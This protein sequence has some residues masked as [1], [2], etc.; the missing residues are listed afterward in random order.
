M[1]R[2]TL[3]PKNLEEKIRGKNKDLEEKIEYYKKYMDLV[4]QISQGKYH[5]LENKRKTAKKKYNDGEITIY[6]QTENGWKEINTNNA[7]LG[8]I[9][10]DMTEKEITESKIYSR[11]AE[12]ALADK[13]IPT[14]SKNYKF[15]PSNLDEY[16][17]PT[18]TFYLDS[19]AVKAMRNTPPDN[20]KAMD[21]LVEKNELFKKTLIPITEKESEKFG[22]KDEKIGEG[23]LSLEE[24]LKK[25]SENYSEKTHRLAKTFIDI[26]SEYF[27]SLGN[28]MKEEVEN[29][30]EK[31]ESAL[32]EKGYNISTENKRFY[33]KLHSNIVK[34]KEKDESN[35]GIINM[36][37]DSILTTATMMHNAIDDENYNIIVSE[38]ADLP[39]IEDVVLDEILPKYLAKITL[40][41]K[42]R[43]IDHYKGDKE[44]AL[45]SLEETA[46]EHIAYFRKE[47]MTDQTPILTQYNFNKGEIKTTYIHKGLTALFQGESPRPKTNLIAYMA[48]NNLGAAESSKKLYG[49]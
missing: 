36:L 21:E 44:L 14:N 3:T 45:K 35:R 47:P 15:N 7:S 39:I 40:E 26:A 32:K 38:D 2:K 33:A 19:N 12:E 13:N 18:Y 6:E 31:W 5:S 28:D 34:W 4:K 27:I 43:I 11:L 37:G 48:K 8:K 24:N 49:V 22:L 16:K 9:I 30:N 23:L 41:E 42:D 17:G 1:N 20:L 29:K 10:E 46:R 25:I